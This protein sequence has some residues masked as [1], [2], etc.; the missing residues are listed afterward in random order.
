MVN[1]RGKKYLHIVAIWQKHPAWSH[2]ASLV[3]HTDIRSLL[4]E[5]VSGTKL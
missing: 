3:G 1:Y 2:L 4:M 5:A